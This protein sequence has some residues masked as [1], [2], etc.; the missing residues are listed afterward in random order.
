MPSI[1][2]FYQIIWNNINHLDKA[3]YIDS[4]NVRKSYRELSVDIQKFFRFFNNQKNQLTVILAKK[5]YHNYCA[6]LATVLSGNTWIPLSL[7]NPWER[8]LEIIMNL[9]PKFFFTDMNYQ[10]K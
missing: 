7:E 10:M 8:N 2:D 4:S 1:N 3:F 5:N 6:I 9:K